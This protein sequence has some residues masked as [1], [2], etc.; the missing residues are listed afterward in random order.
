MVVESYDKHGDRSVRNTE[1]IRKRI[2][3]SAACAESGISET[4]IRV[5]G[6]A[7]CTPD[8]M[9]IEV[10]IPDVKPGPTVPGDLS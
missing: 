1:H 2:F 9:S 6:M 10:E 3:A 5:A 4:M 7:G 8:G